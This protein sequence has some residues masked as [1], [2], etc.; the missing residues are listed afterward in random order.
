[1]KYTDDG[2]YKLIGMHYPSI[3][4]CVIALQDLKTEGKQVTVET[5]HPVDEVFE[6]MWKLY[7]ERDWKKIKEVV[8]AS[9]V[10]PRELNTFFWGSAIVE[11][12][13]N[14]KLIQITLVSLNCNQ[15]THCSCSSSYD[16]CN[17]CS[18]DSINLS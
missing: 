4:N 13:I 15:E 9:T 8:L 1:M 5:V 14:I 16:K 10:D 12:P 6:E 2:L 3:R 7:K 18:I 11:E 17:S